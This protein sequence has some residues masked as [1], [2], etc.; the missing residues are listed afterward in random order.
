MG[1]LINRPSKSKVKDCFS[2]VLIILFGIAFLTG[3]VIG[4]GILFNL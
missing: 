4:C 1:T 2:Y 3:S